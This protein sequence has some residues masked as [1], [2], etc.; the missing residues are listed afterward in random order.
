MVRRF[1]AFEAAALTDNTRTVRQLVI[2]VTA[3]GAEL[4]GDANSGF[5]E[6]CPKPLSMQQIQQLVQK[7]FP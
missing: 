6:V 7:Y 5:D 1:R 4:V 3:N 2:A